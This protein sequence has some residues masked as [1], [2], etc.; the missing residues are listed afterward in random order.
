ME[1]KFTV[2]RLIVWARSQKS[3]LSGAGRRA[4]LYS[5][6]GDQRNLGYLRRA[7]PMRLF[8]SAGSSHD[9]AGNAARCVILGLETRY[10]SDI[11][12]LMEEK[13][14]FEQAIHIILCQ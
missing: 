14:E 9:I 10:F 1:T 6:F 11:N 8:S 5:A 13:S 3:E 4:D 12:D 7:G 2:R